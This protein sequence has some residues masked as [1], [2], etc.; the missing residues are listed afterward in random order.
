VC[1]IAHEKVPTFVD[2][3]ETFRCELCIDCPLNVLIEQLIILDIATAHGWWA[4][5]QIWQ[6]GRDIGL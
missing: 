1:L 4:D 5:R 6:T 2:L 3:G